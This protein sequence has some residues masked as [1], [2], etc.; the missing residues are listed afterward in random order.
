MVVAHENTTLSQ[1]EVQ[2]GI[3]PFA[4]NS[5]LVQAAGWAKAMKLHSHR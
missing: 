3:L 4:V 2:R 1:I 5:T